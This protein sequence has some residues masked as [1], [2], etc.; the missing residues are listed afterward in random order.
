[1]DLMEYR[2]KQLFIQYGI[3]A[4]NGPII[5]SA[6]ELDNEGM[7]EYPVMIKAQVPTGGRGK[8]GGIKFCKDKEAAKKAA[9]DIIGMSIK[10]HEV[11]VE[12]DR[13]TALQIDGETVL[14]VTSYTVKT[15][16]LAKEKEIAAAE[17]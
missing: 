6:D 1:M 17:V 3:A 7:P 14:D 12:F 16:K 9:S 11:T 5:T 15:G 10:G 8:A 2:A 13:P 4:T